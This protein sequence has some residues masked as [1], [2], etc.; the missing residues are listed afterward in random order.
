[1]LKVATCVLLMVLAGAPLHA[2]SGDASGKHGARASFTTGAS[3]G[4][5]GT[6]LGLAA[7]LAFRVRDRLSLEFELAHARQLDFTIDLCPPPRVCV[8]GGQLPVTGRTVTLVPHLVMEL[9][10]RSSRL[11]AY[12]QAG[13][14][15][16]HVRQRYTLRFG[17]PVE[18]TR[19]NLT[20]ALSAGGGIAFRIVPRLT[21]GADVRSLHV[22]DDETNPDQFITPSE[23]LST[24]RVGCRVSWEF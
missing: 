10:P 8:I 9:L 13:I 17:P 19:S 24:I 5:G 4:D 6:A 3:F 12:A 20:A 11:R 16:G 23:V 7:A 21:V 1:M 22:L 14:G 2:Q 18:F 15:A